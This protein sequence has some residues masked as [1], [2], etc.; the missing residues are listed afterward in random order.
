MAACWIF[1]T[2]SL[3]M[4]SVNHLIELLIRTGFFI[5]RIAVPAWSLFF[6]YFG[7]STRNGSKNLGIHLSD[8]ARSSR[9]LPS[10]LSSIR[11]YEIRVCVGKIIFPPPRFEPRTSCTESQCSD[12]YA[13]VLLYQ[14]ISRW[15]YFFPL[16]F[17]FCFLGLLDSW[18]VSGL[19]PT[20]FCL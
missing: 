12:H 19:T 7:P 6:S 18:D 20:E 17:V 2:M 3:Q 5:S 13:T 10:T 1:L 4:S 16:I 14:C 15:N 11:K 9:Q 8:S